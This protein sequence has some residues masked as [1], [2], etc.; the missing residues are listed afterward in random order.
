M[1]KYF[2][3]IHK[4]KYKHWNPAY[5]ESGLPQKINKMIVNLIDWNS[6]QYFCIE[7]N[8]ITAVSFVEKSGLR[9]QFF[10]DLFPD[11]TIQREGGPREARDWTR[12]RPDKMPIYIKWWHVKLH[13]VCCVCS[14][15]VSVLGVSLCSRVCW[16]WNACGESDVDLPM[17]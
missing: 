12:N 14:V 6:W 1:L 13:C 11:L 9:I 16:V 3:P 17:A 2:F 7:S 4:A 5:S 15:A 8:E 10:L